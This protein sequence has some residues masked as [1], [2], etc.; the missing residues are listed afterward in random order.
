VEGGETG[1][2]PSNVI[3]LVLQSYS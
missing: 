1:W 3:Y 2:V